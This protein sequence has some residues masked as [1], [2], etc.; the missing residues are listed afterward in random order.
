MRIKTSVLRSDLCDFDDMRIVAKG[1]TT[2]SAPN[3]AKK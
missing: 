2:V 1:D 3:N